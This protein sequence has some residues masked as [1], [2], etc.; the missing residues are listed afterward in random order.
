L[1]SE[2]AALAVSVKSAAQ[3]AVD[4]FLGSLFDALAPAL[5]IAL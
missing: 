3:A 1:R 5:K 2:A 4:A